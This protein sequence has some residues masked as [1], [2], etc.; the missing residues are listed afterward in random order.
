MYKVGK[1]KKKNQFFNLARLL[2]GRLQVDYVE[3]GAK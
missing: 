1:V 3:N 2:F